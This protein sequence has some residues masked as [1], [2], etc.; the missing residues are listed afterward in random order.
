MSTL[1]I[2]NHEHSNETAEQIIKNV[3]HSA[4]IEQ[5]NKT[6][7]VRNDNQQPSDMERNC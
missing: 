5:I 1:I 2:C 3:H 4:F 6:D 7:N